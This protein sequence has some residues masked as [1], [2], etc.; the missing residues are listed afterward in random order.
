[1][2]RIRLVKEYNPYMGNTS[3]YVEERCLLWWDRISGLNYY[4]ELAARQLYERLSTQGAD[5]ITTIVESL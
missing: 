1:M 4:D 5:V 2:K 3:W